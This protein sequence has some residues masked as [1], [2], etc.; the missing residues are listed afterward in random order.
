MACAVLC[1]AVLCCAVLCCAVLCCA[2]ECRKGTIVPESGKYL[3][4]ENIIASLVLG[5]RE[6]L[7]CEGNDSPMMWE[8]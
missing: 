7:P 3:V 6:G 1:C 5:V 2:V 8:V 4:I